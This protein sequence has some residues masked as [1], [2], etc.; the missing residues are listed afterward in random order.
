MAQDF[1]APASSSQDQNAGHKWKKLEL[2][3]RW[4]LG[5]VGIPKKGSREGR[6]HTRS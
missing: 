2:V 3:F 5:D 6:K 4:G 1:R